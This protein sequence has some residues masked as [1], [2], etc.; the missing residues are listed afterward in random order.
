MKI[1]LLIADG[2]AVVRETISFWLVNHAEIQVV[3]LAQ[4]GHIAVTLACEL[5]PDVV[6]MDAAMPCLNGIEA[7]RGIVRE[8]PGTRVLILS[9][10]VRGQSVFDAIAVGASGYLSKDCSTEELVQAIHGVAQGG[11]YLSPAVSSILVRDYAKG[12]NGPATSRWLSLTN[13][14]RQVLQRIVEGRSTKWIARD[15]SISPKTIDWHKSRMMKKLG[16]DSIAG[17]VRYA[18]TEGLTCD[19]PPPVGVS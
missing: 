3:G 19:A 7:T 1:R 11:T 2:H 10:D 15:L 5:Q 12:R 6:L 8:V 13:R 18:I 16:I 9:D 17:L 14:E 4:N